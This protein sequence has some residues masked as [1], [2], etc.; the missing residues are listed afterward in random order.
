MNPHQ[1]SLTKQSS[2]KSAIISYSFPVKTI[3][4]EKGRDPT[5]SYDKSPT[6]AE[7]SNGQN[8][9]TN[10]ATK[11]S[12]T[13]ATFLETFENIIHVFFYVQ[14]SICFAGW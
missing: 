14:V 12:I 10:N 11:S 2:L 7:M 9:N 13:R 6:P 5:Q 3:S 1:W 4:R 8:D